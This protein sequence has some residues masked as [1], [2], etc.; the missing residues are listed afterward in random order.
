[1]KLQVVQSIDVSLVRITLRLSRLALAFEL[2]TIKRVPLDQIQ[3]RSAWVVVLIGQIL[4]P[5]VGFTLG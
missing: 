5:T 1:M 3:N 4:L 2:N